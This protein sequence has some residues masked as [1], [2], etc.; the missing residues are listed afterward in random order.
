MHHGPILLAVAVV[1]AAANISAVRRLR[2]VA[3]AAASARVVKPIPGSDNQRP[4]SA[5]R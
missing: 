1:A 3:L 5:S 4:V 2:L